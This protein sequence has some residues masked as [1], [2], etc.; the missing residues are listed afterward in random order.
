M[1]FFQE[2]YFG[3]KV[4]Y[5]GLKFQ[6]FHVDIVHF[7]KTASKI[8]QLFFTPLYPLQQTRFFILTNSIAYFLLQPIILFLLLGKAAADFACLKLHFFK[9]A[10]R[11]IFISNFGLQT[12][13]VLECAEGIQ[14]VDFIFKKEVSEDLAAYHLLLYFT[15]ALPYLIHL[16]LS[17][18]YL[19]L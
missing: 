15:H 9:H 5:L 16:Q 19:L 4:R 8:N 11:L 13:E 7:G 18:F 1:P 2:R 14:T 3:F 12:G 6:V 10:H 17:L